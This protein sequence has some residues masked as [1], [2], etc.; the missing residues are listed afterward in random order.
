MLCVHGKQ[1]PRNIIM[2]NNT[3]KIILLKTNN[4]LQKLKLQFDNLVL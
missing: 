1:L 3:Y 2:N 4:Y